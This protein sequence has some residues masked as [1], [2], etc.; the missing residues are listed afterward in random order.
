MTPKTCKHLNPFKKTQ[1]VMGQI[2]VFVWAG[3][4]GDF[5]GCVN[6]ICKGQ[7]EE[8]SE[9][10]TQFTNCRLICLLCVVSIFKTFLPN[11]NNVSLLH[12]LLFPSCLSLF[13]FQAY[14]IFKLLGSVRT[15]WVNI[16]NWFGMDVFHKCQLTANNKYP[17]KND[18]HGTLFPLNTTGNFT[19]FWVLGSI[20]CIFRCF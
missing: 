14:H 18:L 17:T 19:N 11:W 7:P 12:N 20:F 9:N 3:F 2:V 13:H 1:C 4:L 5:F 15:I 10:W 6:A 8:W 16:F